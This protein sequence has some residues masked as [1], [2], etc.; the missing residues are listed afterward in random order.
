M[1]ASNEFETLIT[2]PEEYR[3]SISVN[4]SY[5]TQ[6]GDPMCVHISSVDGSLKLYNNNTKVMQGALR[7]CLTWTT[8]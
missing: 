1:E 8:T 2:I 5:V 4:N 6:Y 7:Q 3:P